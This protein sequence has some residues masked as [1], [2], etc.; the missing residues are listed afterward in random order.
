M[1]GVEFRSAEMATDLL[2]IGVGNELRGDDGIGLYIAGQVSKLGLE[3][4]AVVTSDGDAASLL[5]TWKGAAKVIVI[6]AVASAAEPGRIFRFDAAR[7]EIPEALFKKS[8]SHDFGVLEA[9]GL[10][11]MLSMLP[12]EL[13]I[14]GV[15]GESFDA[16]DGI[17]KEVKRAAAEVIHK[18][19]EDIN[20]K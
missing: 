5:E 19:I 9:V 10:G 15:E 7:E 1:D 14:Y 4:V 11:R 2:V 12:S 3:D 16:G 18:I 20:G 13:I 8:S 17:T 6:D